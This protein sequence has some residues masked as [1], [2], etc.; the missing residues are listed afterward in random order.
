MQNSN[1]YDVDKQICGY[2]LYI[3]IVKGQTSD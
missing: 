2:N 1:I 3:W